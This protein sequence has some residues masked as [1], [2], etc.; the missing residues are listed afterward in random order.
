MEDSLVQTILSYLQAQ[1]S[2]QDCRFAHAFSPE[3]KPHPV[4]RV[5]VTAGLLQAEWAPGGFGGYLGRTE[6]G[7][8]YGRRLNAQVRLAVYAP[9]SLGGARCEAVAAAVCRALEGQ[10][11]P[12]VKAVSCGKA[13]YDSSAQAFCLNCD[14]TIQALY[15]AVYEQQKV[16]YVT[17]KGG[18]EE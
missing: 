15:A 10:E 14:V 18:V 3:E 8:C 7:E 11:E 9:L 4:K 6:A 12:A 1:P 2:L 16:R 17:V 13:S 5:L